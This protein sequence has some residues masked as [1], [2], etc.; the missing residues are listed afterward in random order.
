[1]KKYNTLIRIHLLQGKKSDVAIAKSWGL[2]QNAMGKVRE[3]FGLPS[4]RSLQ[5]KRNE[6]I[7]AHSIK[8]VQKRKQFWQENSEKAVKMWNDGVDVLDIGKELSWGVPYVYQKLNRMKHQGVDVKYRRSV[9]TYNR[10]LP[11]NEGEKK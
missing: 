8:V 10:I 3:Y 7:V 2:N 9:W 1:M 11:E 6:K 5:K 4:R